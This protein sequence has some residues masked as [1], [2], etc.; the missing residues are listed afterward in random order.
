LNRYFFF[1]LIC[2]ITASS[3][4]QGEYSCKRQIES[5]KSDQRARRE[6]EPASSILRGRVLVDYKRCSQKQKDDDFE[7]IELFKV[8]KNKNDY[9]ANKTARLKNL[10]TKLVKDYLKPFKSIFSEIVNNSRYQGHRSISNYLRLKREILL[11]TE[12]IFTPKSFK[13][14]RKFLDSKIDHM[15]EV[16][17]RKLLKLYGYTKA[18]TDKGIYKSQLFQKKEFTVLRC[19][20]R[21]VPEQVLT[22]GVKEGLKYSHSSVTSRLDDLWR[23][24]DIR[25]PFAEG[26]AEQCLS[27]HH[28]NCPRLSDYLSQLKGKSLKNR[29]GYLTFSEFQGLKFKTKSFCDPHSCS[30]ENP[31]EYGSG[32]SVWGCASKKVAAGVLQKAIGRSRIKNPEENEYFNK[33][34]Q[35]LAPYIKLSTLQGEKPKIVITPGKGFPEMAGY[36]QDIIFKSLKDQYQIEIKSDA[37]FPLPLIIPPLSKEKPQL[38]SPDLKFCER[39]KVSTLRITKTNKQKKC[40]H[41]AQKKEVS[42]IKSCLGNTQLT[43]FYISK[44]DQ[45]PKK[46]CVQVSQLNDFQKYRLQKAVISS[47]KS[48]EEKGA[49]R[50]LSPF[51][52]SYADRMTQSSAQALKKNPSCKSYNLNPIIKY[53]ENKDNPIATDAYSPEKTE[54]QRREA[55]SDV[56]SD[57]KSRM[58]RVRSTDLTFNQERYIT[59]CAK[60]FPKLSYYPAKT[61]QQISDF[62]KQDEEAMCQRQP[63]SS[64]DVSELS[65]G[66][67]RQ[68][69][70]KSAT[71]KSLPQF[72]RTAPIGQRNRIKAIQASKDYKGK[73]R[74]GFEEELIT[75]Y[76]TQCFSYESHLAISEIKEKC[77]NDKNNPKCRLL[78]NYKAFSNLIKFTEQQNHEQGFYDPE[79]RKVNHTLKKK[80]AV[81]MTKLPEKRMDCLQ[82]SL[83]RRELL[84][85]AKS[86]GVKLDQVIPPT[87]RHAFLKVVGSRRGALQ[88]EGRT[89]RNNQIVHP[90]I[91]RCPRDFKVTKD[92]GHCI[93]SRSKQL[94]IKSKSQDEV[95]CDIQTSEPGGITDNCQNRRCKNPYA[96]K[97]IGKV[98]KKIASNPESYDSENFIKDSIKHL[99]KIEKV[100]A[101]CRSVINNKSLTPRINDEN[102]IKKIKKYKNNLYTIEGSS[103]KTISI[104]LKTNNENCPNLDSKFYSEAPRDKKF[105]CKKLGI[106]R[107]EKLSTTELKEIKESFQAQIKRAHKLYKKYEKFKPGLLKTGQTIAET[108]ITGIGKYAICLPVDRYT[109]EFPSDQLAIPTYDSET[110]IGRGNLREWCSSEGGRQ[111]RDFKVSAE[112]AKQEIEE[113]RLVMESIAKTVTR[114]PALG[115]GLKPSEGKTSLFSAGE[116]SIEDLNNLDPSISLSLATG[117]EKTCVKF[118]KDPFSTS[119]TAEPANCKVKYRHSGNIF[120]G[121]Y[122]KPFS[123]VEISQ[124]SEFEENYTALDKELKELCKNE[125]DQDGEQNKFLRLLEGKVGQ[126]FISDNPGLEEVRSC[127][128]NKERAKEQADLDADKVVERIVMG[129][130]LAAGAL[131]MAPP[132]AKVAGAVGDAICTGWY[133]YSSLGKRYQTTRELQSYLSCLYKGDKSCSIDDLTKMYERH[134]AAISDSNME[135]AMVP[136]FALGFLGDIKEVAHYRKFQKANKTLARLVGSNASKEAIEAASSAAKNELKATYKELFKLEEFTDSDLRRISNMSGKPTSFLKNP[137]KYMLQKNRMEMIRKLGFEDIQDQALRRKMFDLLTDNPEIIDALRSGWTRGFRPKR[138]FLRGLFENEEA[139]REFLEALDGE[140]LNKFVKQMKAAA[141]GGTEKIALESMR[142]IFKDAPKALEIIEHNLD[143]LKPFSRTRQVSDAVIQTGAKIPGA[144]YSAMALPYRVIKA[145]RKELSRIKA[146]VRLIEEIIESNPERTVN[147]ELASELEKLKTS[148]RVSTAEKALIKIKKILEAGEGSSMSRRISKLRKENPALKF[149]SDEEIIKSLQKACGR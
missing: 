90:K 149:F 31:F 119:F 76:A 11:S 91:R 109:S 100:K 93:T 129:T 41:P 120:G 103:L 49:Q 87:T 116:I 54:V 123:S 86:T 24:R 114:F 74:T 148:V 110:I 78:S 5:Y 99:T 52:Y 2:L 92:K 51:Q 143:L 47:V 12:S 57:R 55:R 56:Y 118:Y 82:T 137:S 102:Y 77:N 40:L 17:I 37:K 33:L 35:R 130:C 122:E 8:I 60:G 38:H 69:L 62:I 117:D 27:E 53:T 30:E 138:S 4:A 10:S 115:V 132:P 84:A 15:P 20:K 144:F 48:I 142:E 105:Q 107:P 29:C 80:F 45:L 136:L 135:M 101:I 96:Q 81:C 46:I 64:C 75:K 50:S 67:A 70:F 126:D 146:Q 59:R 111:T 140:N 98:I 141:E 106:K 32:F 134:D 6:P 139:L 133:L 131:T 127:L 89:N 23:D 43:K 108:L 58:S 19:K 26:F 13:K 88:I 113:F 124:K 94:S 7:K 63:T 85:M 145:N 72:V 18:T 61:L 68:E 25:I 3:Y 14:L 125:E 112:R 97:R 73:P 128:L 9:D 36:Y 104:R 95:K 16:I 39:A 79:T 121:Y 147:S 28:C 71:F 44:L 66:Q 1:T 34:I 65:C 21:K 83:S 42:K 22:L